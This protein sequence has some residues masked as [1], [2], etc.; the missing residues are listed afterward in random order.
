MALVND[1]FRKAIEQT[2]FVP[3]PFPASR[4]AEGRDL[5]NKK[6]FFVQILANEF[7][8]KNWWGCGYGPYPSHL[9]KSWGSNGQFWNYS[10]SIRFAQVVRQVVRW[11]VAWPVELVKDI[12]RVFSTPHHKYL[13]LKT[14]DCEDIYTTYN[15]C[16]FLESIMVHFRYRA[17]FVNPPNWSTNWSG[18]WSGRSWNSPNFKNWK[19]ENCAKNCS[20]VIKIAEVGGTLYICQIKNIL[21]S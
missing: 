20:T 11:P 3:F 10:A 5:E 6:E 9:K 16:E 14:S 13:I 1:S 17:F 18:N 15:F 21:W 7:G 19:S 8:D 4:W 2:Q 12:S